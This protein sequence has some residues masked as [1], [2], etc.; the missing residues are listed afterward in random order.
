[1]TDEELEQRMAEI[2][3]VTVEEMRAYDPEFA[4]ME[5][6]RLEG[7]AF[8]DHIK[9]VLEQVTPEMTK[10][11]E[12]TSVKIEET[13]ADESMDENLYQPR[14]SALIG[15]S[16]NGLGTIF[17]WLSN[18]D[19]V[20][21]VHSEDKYYETLLTWCQARKRRNDTMID[22]DIPTVEDSGDW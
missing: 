4:I 7:Q 20:M 15:F 11:L 21:E 17:I 3:S 13:L 22:V 1:M 9:E 12:K 2:F 10:E 8:W 18:P 5:Q 16:V 14:L 6:Q 19:F